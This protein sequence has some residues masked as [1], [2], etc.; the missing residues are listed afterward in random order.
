MVWHG[1]AEADVSALEG[2]DLAVAAV[3]GA[4]A[5][6]AWELKDSPDA[7]AAMDWSP[8]IRDRNRMSR[9]DWTGMGD[10]PPGH[11]DS[12]S[13]FRPEAAAHRLAPYFA[14]RSGSLWPDLLVEARRLIRAAR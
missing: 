6:M 13:R 11:R 9:G 7:Y 4:V 14:P 8:I 10:A 1:V 2:P 5:G 3:A 12:L